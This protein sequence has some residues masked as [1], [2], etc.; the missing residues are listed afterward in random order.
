MQ[1]NNY[2]HTASSGCTVWPYTMA[3]LCASEQLRC[4]A[5]AGCSCCLHSS[6]WYDPVAETRLFWCCALLCC[7]TPTALHLACL[8]VL[9]AGCRFELPDGKPANLP[10]ASCI[11]TK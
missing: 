5:S 7:R 4:I 1:G 10:V 9:L 11:L 6:D 3:S 8:A 2:L